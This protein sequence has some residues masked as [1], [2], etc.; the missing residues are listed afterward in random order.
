MMD[1]AITNQ[2][3]AYDIA[4][5]VS[6]VKI[7]CPEPKPREQQ[8]RDH[9]FSKEFEEKSKVHGIYRKIW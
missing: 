7:R 5:S 1:T 4:G 3:Q 2:S 9:H 6:K 8:S